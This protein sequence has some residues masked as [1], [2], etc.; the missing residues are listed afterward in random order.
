MKVEEEL[1]HPQRADVVKPEG[2]ECLFD[3]HSPEQ[4]QQ[5]RLQAQM[6]GDGNVLPIP[7]ELLTFWPQAATTH[8]FEP[9][10]NRLKRKDGR[11]TRLHADMKC[12]STFPASCCWNS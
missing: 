8:L 11:L 12:C 5:L 9:V 4:A 3:L 1:A 10:T 6:A 2:G 7:A